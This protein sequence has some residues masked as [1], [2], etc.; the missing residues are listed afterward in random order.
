MQEILARRV[1]IKELENPDDVYIMP[2][3]IGSQEDC[4]GGEWVS[5]VKG[6][7]AIDSSSDENVCPPE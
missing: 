4:D 2:M 7:I 6:E 3:D 5:L 1:D